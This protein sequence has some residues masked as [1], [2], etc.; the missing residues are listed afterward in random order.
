MNLDLVILRLL[1]NQEL[2]EK[3]HETIDERHLKI[4]NKE[5]FQL[6][7]NLRQLKEQQQRNHSPEE[8]ALFFY[9]KYPV[10][11]GAHKEIY[12]SL[13]AELRDIKVQFE[14]AA[15]YFQQLVDRING[16]K[17][18]EQL[19]SGDKS[20]A[21]AKAFLDS[22]VV[23]KKL[24][25]EVDF[26]PDDLDSLQHNIDLS[27]GLSWRLDVLN[28]SIGKL[29]RGNFVTVFAPPETGKTAFITS[30][31][32]QMLRDLQDGQRAVYFLNEEAGFNI[33]LRLYQAYFGID[34]R[35]LFHNKAEY[36]R[37]IREEIGGKILM[38]DSAGINKATVEKICKEVEPSLIVIDNLDKI[39]G[40]IGER[41]D[42][43]L[44]NIYWWARELAKRYAPLI[45]VSQ[46]CGEG[47]DKLYLDMEDM[48]GSRIA[49]QGE[50]DVII[51]IGK[52]S[53]RAEN[54][55]GLAVLKNKLGWDD[56]CDPSKR[57]TKSQVLIVPE[58]SKYETL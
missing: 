56:D 11:Q 7:T 6:L 47:I 53:G 43:R 8:F 31:T 40:F 20:L 41:G 45:G 14:N 17:L 37:R 2:F 34:R 1:L 22:V 55:R 4:H 57:H 35:E 32:S 27:G 52:D 28:K 33:K 39:H 12:D 58:E 51:G 19:L 50:A 38:Y 49:K 18:A 15:D 26:V 30:E 29:R 9:G 36:D 10:L 24:T 23:E 46:A 44:K 16:E 13:F 21:D 3:F 5:V 54:I 42:I 25:D 48:D